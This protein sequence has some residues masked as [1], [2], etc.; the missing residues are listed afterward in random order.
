MSPKER[1]DYWN[2]LSS[3]QRSHLARLVER[4]EKAGIFWNLVAVMLVIMAVFVGFVMLSGPKPTHTRDR[5]SAVVPGC[6]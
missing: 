1:R 6:E 5:P 3:E 2:T 4:P